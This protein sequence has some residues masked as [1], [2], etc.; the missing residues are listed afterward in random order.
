M[1]DSSKGNSDIAGK[2]ARISSGRAGGDETDLVGDDEF[3]REY[4][5]IVSLP[6]NARLTTGDVDDVIEAVRCIVE[7]HQA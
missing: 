6:L 2:G 1:R 4:E 5:R 7:T 3:Q